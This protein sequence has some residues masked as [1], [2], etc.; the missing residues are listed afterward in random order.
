MQISESQTRP[1]KKP[2][3]CV[4]MQAGVVY[5]KFCRI[6]F[7]CAECRFDRVM[8]RVSQRNRT[9]KESDRPLKGKRGKIMPWKDKLMALPASKR[10]CVHHMKG[11]INFRVCTHKYQCGNCDFDQ[12][13]HDEH[14][15][16]AVVSP[17]DF[18]EVH[19]FK[20]PQGYYFHPGHTWAKIEEDSSVRVGLDEFALRV[21]GPLDRV[22]APLLGKQVKQGDADIQLRRGAQTALALSPVSGV[23]TAINTRLR[24]KGCLANKDPFSDG[25]VLRL[26]SNNLRRDLKELMIHKE[27]QDFMERE[28]ETLYSLIEDT[29]GPLPT[30]GGHPGKDIYGNMP[31]LGWERL[32]KVFLRT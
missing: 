14:S 3:P 20:I 18:L 15:V 24:Q 30:D 31:Q 27:T 17:I 10:P 11:R 5:E 26:H 23:V 19:G 16:H 2:C 6:D 12:F 28:I 9:L 8:S 29:A 4:W 25:W 32:C 1:Y 13:F 22:E 7:N 21:L